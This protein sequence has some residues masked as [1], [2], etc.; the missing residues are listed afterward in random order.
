MPHPVAIPAVAVRR[1]AA[2]RTILKSR[3][4]GPDE[5]PASITATLREQRT[6]NVNEDPSY[7]F[8]G[9]GDE[10]SADSSSNTRSI[11]SGRVV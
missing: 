10:P 11:M 8:A 3:S 7:S 6:T 2:T 1:L 9:S 5:T 4:S